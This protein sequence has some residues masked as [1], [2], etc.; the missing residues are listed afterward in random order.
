MSRTDLSF[1]RPGRPRDEKAHDLIIDA[2]LESFIEEGLEG[3]S[4]E[5]IAARAGVGKATIYRRWHSKE[6][7][8]SEAIARCALDVPPLDT[9]S[10]RGDLTEMIRKM[11]LYLSGDIG[12]QI[13]PRM[14]GEVW[15]NSP[16]GKEFY[17][18]VVRPRRQVVVDILKHGVE[19]GELRAGLD[20]EL[21]ADALTGAVIMRLML[22]G[23][24]GRSLEVAEE[25]VDLLLGGLAPD[26]ATS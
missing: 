11:L 4:V 15:S 21:A 26:P 1:R 3:A 2:A 24:S 8:I 10:T 23:V 17:E 12:G 18:A 9:G 6:D 5:G 7:L 20:I 25:L 16:F 22:S 13:F 14:V 19:R